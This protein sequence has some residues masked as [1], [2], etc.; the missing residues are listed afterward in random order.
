VTPDRRSR[1]RLTALSIDQL[2]EGLYRRTGARYLYV[3]LGIQY[4]LV[5]LFIVPLYTAF[6][7]PVFEIT[8]AE[9]FEYLLVFEPFYILVGGPVMFL[10]IRMIQR[11]ALRWLK[12]RSPE[13]APAAW[14]SIVAGFPLTAMTI[15][16]WYLLVTVPPLLIV[17][18]RLGLSALGTA[19]YLAVL[20]FL[21]AAVTI[22]AYL[23]FEQA[24]RPVVS[25]IAA[26]LPPGFRS[27]RRT[28]SFGAK[29]LLLLPAINLFTGVFVGAIAN[30]SLGVEGS[31]AVLLGTS[32]LVSLTL[33]L[34]LTL[35][36][37][38]S[39]LIRLDDV[40]QAINRVD[41]GDYG[42]RLLPRAGDELDD[43]GGRFNRMAAGLQERESLRDDLRASRA[44]IVAASD[45]ERRRMERDLHD[46]AQQHLVL[47]KM[48]LGMLEDNLDADSGAKA[49]VEELKSDLGRALAELRD[50]AHGIYP[51]ILEH[52]GL[53]AALRDAAERSPLAARVESNRA[54]RYPA[55]L[56]AAV[57]FCCLEAL[58]NAAKHAPESNVTV[59]LAESDGALRFE[60]ADDGPGFDAASQNGSAGLQNMAD[61]IGAL[62]GRLEIKSSPSLGTRVTGKVPLGA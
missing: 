61:R 39:L 8:V 31:L 18:G 16:L 3:L 52:E 10:I 11:P 2:A 50:L 45:Q 14:E 34:G 29:A 51:A 26:Q 55:E 48:K 49:A 54:G 32:L 17:S 15:G 12:S 22:F 56:E 62:G 53:P 20:A 13:E 58:Q 6:L 36:F 44:R 42:T 9:F 19:L 37:R 33:S 38:R 41:K 35:I 60:I 28:P 43:I 23:S 4:A 1:G 57:Y 7:A 47:L 21:I 59:S 40:R 25:E 27:R 46:G 30:T 5:V 24:L